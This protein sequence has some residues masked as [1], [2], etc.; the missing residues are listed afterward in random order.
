V[1]L[2][3]DFVECGVYF[4]FLSSIIMDYLDWNEA[5]GSRQ[6]LLIDSF[7]GLSTET[8]SSDELS[9][10]RDTKYGTDYE[11]TFDGASA[12]LG[13]FANTQLI[14]G[15]VPDVLPS[16]SAERIA[17]LHLD[18]NAAAPEI[19]AF[20]Y[21]WDR[22]VPGGVILMDDYAY[23]GYEPQKRA[24]DE[25]AKKLEFSIASLPTGQG[26]VIK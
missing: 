8:L 5:A 23:D 3:G 20:E 4:G 7:E 22:I 12:N 13:R 15:Y 21:F 19:A 25:L 18:M 1:Q 17:Y 2:K 24:F 10:G 26:L 9:L 14:K 11:D 6:F 16:I